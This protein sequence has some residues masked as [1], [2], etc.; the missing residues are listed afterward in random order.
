[1]ADEKINFSKVLFYFIL[2]FIAFL[3]FESFSLIFAVSVALFA[4]YYFTKERPVEELTDPHMAV[5]KEV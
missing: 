4:L 1:M 5:W 2:F 3:V